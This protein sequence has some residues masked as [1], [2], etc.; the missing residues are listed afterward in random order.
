MGATFDLFGPESLKRYLFQYWVYDTDTDQ[1]AAEGSFIAKGDTLQEATRHLMETIRKQLGAT[2]SPS[3][4]LH[5][6]MVDHFTKV[7]ASSTKTLAEQF[8]DA[9]RDQIKKETPNS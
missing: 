5:V 8:F 2:A 1:I 7:P 4:K 6:K 3:H 9:V